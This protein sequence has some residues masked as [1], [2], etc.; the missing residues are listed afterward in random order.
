MNSEINNSE[1]LKYQK[2]A[3]DVIVDFFYNSKHIIERQD[4]KGWFYM[5]KKTANKFK[6]H[7]LK[8]LLR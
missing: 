4:D 8:S 6:R 5:S 7:Y 1:K 3:L 2:E